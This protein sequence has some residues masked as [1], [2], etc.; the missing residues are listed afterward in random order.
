[1]N[2]ANAPRSTHRR[3][4]DAAKSSIACSVGARRFVKYQPRAFH[5]LS[6]RERRTQ[7]NSFRR[8]SINLRLGAAKP[9]H[10]HAIAPQLAQINVVDLGQHSCALRRCNV[11]STVN[12]GDTIA[13]ADTRYSCAKYRGDRRLSSLGKVASTSD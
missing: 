10:Q 7:K 6:I 9:H 2:A 5:N 8:D 13:R 12:F 4:R 3:I 1:M 11:A